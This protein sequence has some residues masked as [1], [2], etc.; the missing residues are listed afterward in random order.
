MGKQI[1]RI[2]LAGP[3]FNETEI[4]NTEYAEQVLKKRGFTFF[5]PM[6]HKVDVEPGTM[7][8]SPCIMEAIPTP[9]RPGSAVMRR[10]SENRSFW[11]TRT[12]KAMPMS[13]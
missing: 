1:Q 3:F 12:E 4:R 11:F 7:R 10:P 13:C 9:E 6:R 5:S 8:W 2:Y